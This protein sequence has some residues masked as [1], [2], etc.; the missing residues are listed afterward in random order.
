MEKNKVEKEDWDP[1]C[2]MSTWNCKDVAGNFHWDG[3]VW[4][5]S[6]RMKA[7]NYSKLLPK[8]KQGRQWGSG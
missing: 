8:G 5:K 6:W 3:D 7:R 1:H 2:P 4:L